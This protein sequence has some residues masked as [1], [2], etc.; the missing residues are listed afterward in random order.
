MEI[1]ITD[2]RLLLREFFYGI[3]F[4]SIIDDEILK[5]ETRSDFEKS[6]LYKLVDYYSKYDIK[7][8]LEN[9]KIKDIDSEIFSKFYYLKNKNYSI[10][11]KTS[12]YLE[13]AYNGCFVDKLS[14]S[15]I[16]VFTKSRLN[17]YSFENMCEL[18]IKKQEYVT[19]KCK[20]ILNN[21][22]LIEDIKPIDV[23]KLLNKGKFPNES[24]VQ[25]SIID[26]INRY[27]D[28]INPVLIH[29]KELD[30]LRRKRYKK[31]AIK[32]ANIIF[33]KILKDIQYKVSINKSYFKMF[34]DG[35][36]RFFNIKINGLTILFS[37]VERHSN[38]EAAT[39]RAIKFTNHRMSD[40]PRSFYYAVDDSL[41][42]GLELI[43]NNGLLKYNIL[44]IKISKPISSFET[45]HN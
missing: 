37:I 17:K 20:A 42:S 29:K 12:A 22:E 11:D 28:S 45:F 19:N 41:K 13:L 27:L 4:M 25:H 24:Q 21:T 3:Y 7:G 34:I 16:E 9:I 1:K 44:A 39:I 38:E 6:D 36:F 32:T 26:G 33:N 5:F 43:L 40:T 35:K 2:N 30:A 31:E 8:I 10:E 14:D 23:S 15:N 18:Y